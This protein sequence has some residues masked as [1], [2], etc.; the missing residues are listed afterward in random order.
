MKDGS[1]SYFVILCESK[2]NRNMI[3]VVKDERPN[4]V[5]EW[6]IS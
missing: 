4:Y 2:Q 5:D 6:K 1:K 3:K